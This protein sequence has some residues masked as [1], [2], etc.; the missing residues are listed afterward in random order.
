MSILMRMELAS[1]GNQIFHGNYQLYN[2]VVT[3]HAF[4]MIFFM[5]MPILIGGFGN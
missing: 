5:V 1:T 2:V 4:L 3:A